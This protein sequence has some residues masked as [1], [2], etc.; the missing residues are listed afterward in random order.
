[1]T[2]SQIWQALRKLEHANL[3]E[4]DRNLLRPAFAAMHGAEAI[5]LPEIVIARIKHLDATLPK[6]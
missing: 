6:D 4:R 5:K 1:M 3:S 2:V